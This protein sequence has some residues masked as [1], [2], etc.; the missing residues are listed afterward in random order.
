MEQLRVEVVEEYHGPP[1]P[2]DSKSDLDEAILTLTAEEPEEAEESLEPFVRA[3]TKVVYSV[4]ELQVP[5]KESRT[6]SCILEESALYS[7]A[8]RVRDKLP[9]PNKH[10][11]VTIQLTN[12]TGTEIERHGATMSLTRTYFS[13]RCPCVCICAFVESKLFSRV[14]TVT[15]ERKGPLQ[16]RWVV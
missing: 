1:K 3:G 2:N 5:K 6:L 14:V 7:V 15:N 11:S 9:V 12:A 13:L 16:P 10:V 4:P 8:L